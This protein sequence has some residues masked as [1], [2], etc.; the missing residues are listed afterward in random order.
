MGWS[1][2][3]LPCE[4]R[5][6]RAATGPSA[7][8]P[9]AGWRL[10]QLEDSWRDRRS[11]GILDELP[12]AATRVAARQLPRSQVSW[13]AGAATPPAS[14]PAQSSTRVGPVGPRACPRRDRRNAIRFRE[15]SRLACSAR[16]RRR[17]ETGAAQPPGSKRR[18]HRASWPD[19][20]APLL[21]Q[22]L[23]HSTSVVK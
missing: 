19:A 17:A 20:L 18:S 1:T 23:G 16:W 15:A 5:E 3:A 10:A 9:S 8:W 14:Q 6:G 12:E 13:P 2:G 4:P 22:S 21:G 11:L 7:T